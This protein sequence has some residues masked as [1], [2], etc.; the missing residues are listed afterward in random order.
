MRIVTSVGAM[1]R[2]ASKWRRQGVPVGLVPTMGYLHRG[3]IAVPGEV[4]FARRKPVG[5]QIKPVIAE[6]ERAKLRVDVLGAAFQ[7]G[8]R[9]DK[10]FDCRHLPR[11]QGG[12]ACRR[13]DVRD[14][15]L[16]RVEQIKSFR[17]LPKELDPEQEGE[18][19]TPTRKI[20]RKLIHEQFKP[21]VDAMYDESEERMVAAST[22]NALRG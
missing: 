13:R 1:Q 20:K 21:L 3:H 15:E 12:R 11:Q 16:A 7:P 17:I 9:H 19:V 22:G 18:A 5:I 4:V 10:K 14:P 6:Q 2:L 8:F